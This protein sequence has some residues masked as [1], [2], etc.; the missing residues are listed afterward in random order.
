MN[1]E[2]VF[3][4]EVYDSVSTEPSAVE[5]E[6]PVVET[7]E[8]EVT[9]TTVPVTIPATEETEPSE[10][11]AP[12]TLPQVILDYIAETEP[13]ETTETNEII[14]DDL[15]DLTAESTSI[16]ANIILCGAL[17]IVG[18]LCGIRFWR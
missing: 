2:T 15:V 6:S 7:T 8:P 5:T 11:V 18:V 4:T 3:P 17:M 13:T 16:L 1:E 10:T 12:E 9:E 14:M